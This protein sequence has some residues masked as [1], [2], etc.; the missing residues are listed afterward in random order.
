MINITIAVGDQRFL[1]RTQRGDNSVYGEKQIVDI[2]LGK[3][4]F[5]VIIRRNLSPLFYE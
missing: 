4:D 5:N 1:D 3:P 2:G